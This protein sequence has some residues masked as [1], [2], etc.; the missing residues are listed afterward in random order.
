MTATLAAR[1]DG[2]IG[3]N[4]VIRIAEALDAES[5]SGLARTVF[6][7]ARIEEHLAAPP[8]GMVPEDEVARLMAALFVELG[9]EAAR[10][11]AREAGRRTADYLIANRIP[12]PA[13]A[14]FRILPKPIAARL[15]ARSVARHAWTFAG[16]GRL[17]LQP[18]PPLVFEI[19]NGPLCRYLRTDAPACDYYVGTFERLFGRL[20]DRRA[21]ALEIACAAAGAD[22]CRFKVDIG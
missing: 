8:A 12:A 16:S 21:R 19:R 18:G 6:R 2:R 14:A 15:L 22:A 20:V 1:Q 13:R 10:R 11:V 9:P 17:V 7:T 3:P 5:R 4:A